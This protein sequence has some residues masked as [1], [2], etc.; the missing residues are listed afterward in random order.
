MNEKWFP[1]IYN[2]SGLESY[3]EYNLKGDIRKRY[4]NEPIKQTGDSVILYCEG[5]RIRVNKAKLLMGYKKKE[6]KDKGK[7]R[8]P[9]LEEINQ[10]IEQLVRAEVARQLSEMFKK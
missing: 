6:R 8:N 1:L 10:K 9:T 4:T 7:K 2:D 3:Y 5:E